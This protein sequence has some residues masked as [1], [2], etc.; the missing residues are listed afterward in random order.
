MNDKPR[1][2]VISAHAADFCSRGGGAIARYVEAG[3]PVRVVA[4]SFG[5]RGESPDLYRARPDVPL[6]EVKRIRRAEA[7]SA[8]AVLGVEIRFMDWRDHPLFITE[9]RFYH[10]VDAIRAWRPRILITHWTTDSLNT[11]H[12]LT[13]R[14]V[15]RALDA[16]SS[17]GVRLDHPVMPWPD[18]FFFEPTLPMTE[19]V[20]FNPDVFL[21]ITSVFE[22][23]LRALRCFVSQSQLPGWY[24]ELARRRAAQARGLTEDSAIEYAEAYKRFRPWVGKVFP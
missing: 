4:L 9:E 3:S 16:A 11:D 10:L 21:D 23:K 8:A 5:E 19:F 20:E 15:L 18:V 12:E 7:E 2:M 6:D 1:V 22:T 17:P 24:T 14:T 13:A